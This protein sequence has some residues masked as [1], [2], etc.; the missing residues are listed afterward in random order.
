MKRVTESELLR[1][2]EYIAAATTKCNHCACILLPC[3]CLLTSEKCVCVCVCVC[4]VCVVCV[5]VVV[6]SLFFPI[7]LGNSC[8][9]LDIGITSMKPTSLRQFG[10]VNVF[11]QP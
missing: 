11:H 7:C 6:V 8:S 5:C 4:V 9:K 3:S 1:L 10:M 2:Q